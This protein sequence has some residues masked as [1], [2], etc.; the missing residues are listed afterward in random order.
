MEKNQNELKNNNFSLFIDFNEKE[1]SA[2]I[3]QYISQTY[4][5]L[6]WFLMLKDCK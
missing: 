5:M 3:C 4:N 2:L 1:L 6:D